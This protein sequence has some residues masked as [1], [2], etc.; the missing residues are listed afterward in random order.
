MAH[1]FLLFPTLGRLKQEDCHEFKASLDYIK[2]SRPH[3]SENMNQEQTKA[4]TANT[5]CMRESLQN[6]KK[7]LKA[8]N[9]A[10][11][12]IVYQRMCSGLKIL[13]LHFSLNIDEYQILHWT[14]IAQEYKECAK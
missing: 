7:S 6:L 4:N 9:C 11:N 13:L 8:F 5:K 2:R 14:E 12:R 3:Y 10:L 1:F